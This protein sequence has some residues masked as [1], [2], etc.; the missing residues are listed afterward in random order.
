MILRRFEVGNAYDDRTEGI[1]SYPKVFIDMNK[2]EHIYLKWIA[3]FEDK[4]PAP[5]NSIFIENKGNT[6]SFFTESGYRKFKSH[7]H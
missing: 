4:L 6:I 1:L 3:I 5:P 7:L 2:D